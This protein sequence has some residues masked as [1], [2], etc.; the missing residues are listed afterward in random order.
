MDVPKTAKGQTWSL[1]LVG[2]IDNEERLVLILVALAGIIAVAGRLASAWNG[3]GEF[4][5]D[6]YY[7]IVTAR[8]Y[9]ATGLISYDG[10]HPTN[11]YHPLWFFLLVGAYWLIGPD[12]GLDLQIFTV[13]VLLAAFFLLSLGAGAHF[14]LAARRRNEPWAWGFM[15]LLIFLLSPFGQNY[16][17]D[18]L[19]STAVVAAFILVAGFFIADRTLPLALAFLF[20]FLARLDTLVFIVFPLLVFLFWSRGRRGAPLVA[21]ASVPAL[22]AF[23]AY[24]A[25]NYLRFGHI[26]PISGELKSSFP[27]LSP[28]FSFLLDVPLRI[29]QPGDPAG[30]KLRLLVSP[31][32]DHL[33]VFAVAAVVLLL[34]LRPARPER[35]RLAAF[36]AV[37]VILVLN[38]LLFQKWEKGIE[39]WYLSLPQVL[40]FF[41]L[42]ALGG[43]WI[44]P[45]E[46]AWSPWLGRAAVALLGVMTIYQAVAAWSLWA[47]S[48]ESKERQFLAPGSALASESETFLLIGF[49]IHGAA[50]TE[51]V[52]TTESGTISFWSRR[53]VISLDGLINDFE[54][55]EYLRD[56]RL[57][58]Y[59]RENRVRYLMVGWWMRNQPYMRERCEP[60]YRCRINPA[61]VAGGNYPPAEFYVYSHMYH[62]YS[63]RILLCPGQEVYRSKLL[64]DGVV[65]C[66]IVIYD[67]KRPCGTRTADPTPIY[68]GD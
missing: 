41:V 16:Q 26:K 40:S 46:Q 21:A 29:L 47:G 19:E 1:N 51:V 48:R 50:P 5:D 3:H 64:K 66:V 44:A 24:S 28:H 63:D 37:L 7:Y 32:L 33:V 23:L 12:A 18:G 54:Y 2:P 27:A 60:M 57:G 35:D 55:Q 39:P 13:S 68:P 4:T 22:A 45:R 36:T 25:S 11:G 53:R 61:A 62:Q 67:L 30:M 43:A 38:L 9:V 58:E 20:L 31:G 42:G 49:L 17:T 8:N 34:L 56:G 6:A 14:W 15:L 65:D 52:A 59:L 10:L